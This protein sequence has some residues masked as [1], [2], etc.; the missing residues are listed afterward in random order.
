MTHATAPFDA[1]D[2]PTIDLTASD[3]GDALAPIEER[4][5]QLEQEN[6]ELRASRSGAAL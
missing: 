5:H 6:A 2:L 1:F 4:L 3:P